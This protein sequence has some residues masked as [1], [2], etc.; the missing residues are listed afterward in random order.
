[1]GRPTYSHAFLNDFCVHMNTEGENRGH[2][3][4]TDLCHAVSSGSVP[5]VLAAAHEVLGWVF[6]GFA[7]LTG[8]TGVIVGVAKRTPPRAYWWAVWGAL[9]VGVVQVSLGLIMFGQ[10]ENPG[11]FHVFYGTVLLFTVAFSYVFKTQL[12]KRPALYWGLLLLFAMGVGLRGIAN[13]GRD[14]GA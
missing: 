5:A 9:G 2:R 3:G 8:L 13:F 1:M 6:V 7:G 11:G 12:S 14:F 4:R 10:G